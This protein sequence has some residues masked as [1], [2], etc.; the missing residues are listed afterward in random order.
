M[1]VETAPVH[2]FDTTRFTTEMR[3]S[4]GR[5]LTYL[6]V[7][8][9]DRCNMRCDYCRPSASSYLA[10][11][12]SDMLSYEEI[13][14]IISVAADLGVTKVRITGGEPLVRRD[15]P[16]LIAQLSA[17]TGIKDLALS[18]N[19]ALLAEYA[20]PLADAGLHRINVS[21]DSLCGERFRQLT[22]GDLQSVLRG[23]H[24]AKE[25]GLT[26]IK[27]NCVLMRG[28][29]DGEAASM[30]DFAVESGATIRF[31]ELMPMKQGMDWQQHYISVEEILARDDVR[32]RVDISAA[33]GSGRWAARY[34]P[35]RGS[36]LSVGFIMPMSDRFCAGCNRLRLTASGGLRSCL[37]ADH[38]LNMRDLL[39]QG[40]SDD[41]IRALFLR[42]ALIKP[43]IGSYDFAPTTV[44][45][46][47]IQIGG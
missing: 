37:P 24:A 42:A 8:V 36:S 4:F 17:I 11:S 6:R 3:D 27:I 21:L 9:T 38:Q 23:I 13:V 15:L 40:G 31:I 47:M 45:R 25:A 43:E 41:E 1:Q 18:T 26:P 20:R 7:S 33:M 10:E 34:L 32:A 2:L 46:S 14:R 5:T 22:G 39:R 28:V 35:V 16:I 12:H 30:I 29:N 19:A 44:K